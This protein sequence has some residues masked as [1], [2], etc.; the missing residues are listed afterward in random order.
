MWLMQSAGDDSFS[1][2]LALLV[3]TI[4]KQRPVRVLV[5]F[6]IIYSLWHLNFFVFSKARNDILHQHNYCSTL[7]RQSEWCG[8]VS[9]LIKSCR[10]CMFILNLSHNLLQFGWAAKWYSYWA[11]PCGSLHVSVCQHSSYISIMKSCQ[12]SCD[13]QTDWQESLHIEC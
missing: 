10:F 8:T 9:D 1:L 5:F 2:T 13:L 6:S 7:V 3:D 11:F 4:N 12:P